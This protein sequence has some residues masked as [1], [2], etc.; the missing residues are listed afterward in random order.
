M[1]EFYEKAV[2]RECL[3]SDFGGDLAS[4]AELHEQF[5]SEYYNLR[6]YFRAEEE[7][8]G[9]YWDDILAKKKDKGAHQAEIIQNFTK[10]EID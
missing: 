8:R 1:D 3:P 5:K 7:Q 4:I 9:S 10:L 2:P 6:E